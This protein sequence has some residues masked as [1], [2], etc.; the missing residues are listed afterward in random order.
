PARSL[1][2]C[3]SIHLS[4]GGIRTDAAILALPRPTSRRRRM[5]ELASPDLKAIVVKPHRPPV[6]TADAYGHSLMPRDGRRIPSQAF[7]EP[8]SDGLPHDVGVHV[9]ASLYGSITYLSVP[10][11]NVDGARLADSVGT[12]SDAR[13]CLAL[14]RRRRSAGGCLVRDRGQ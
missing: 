9:G 5:R 4:Y 3:C 13:L 12:L 7:F 11:V 10:I 6:I 2:N 14:H 1:G 8:L